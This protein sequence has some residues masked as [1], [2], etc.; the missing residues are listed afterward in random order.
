MPLII[1]EGIDRVGKSTL[2]SIISE[3]L[4]IPCFHDKFKPKYLYG[5]YSNEVANDFIKLKMEMLVQT[6]QLAG[7]IVIDRFHLTELVYNYFRNIICLEIVN[8]YDKLLAEMDAVLI[9]VQPENIKL[10]SKN[11]GSDLQKHHDLFNFVFVNSLIKRK[12]ITSYSR[13]DEAVKYAKLFN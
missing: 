2:C 6:L 7:N 8:Y 9:L 11:H 10:A 3:E 12:F 13:L 1:V 5:H 4:K